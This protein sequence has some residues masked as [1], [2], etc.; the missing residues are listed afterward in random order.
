[1]LSNPA[2]IRA[3][4][5]ELDRV[6]GA[7]RTPTFADEPSLPFIRGMVKETLRLRPINKF[8]NNHYN[9]EDD[10][11]E[12]HFI[13]R[14]SIIMAN[15]WAIHYDASVYPEPEKFLPERWLD[16]RYSAAQAAALADGDLRD[17]LSY[18]GGRRI[19]AGMHLAEKSMFINMAR[20]L[21]GFDLGL[22]TDE[23]G[24][25]IEVDFGTTGLMEGSGSIPKPFSCRMTPRSAGREVILREE[26]RAAQETGID[27]SHVKFST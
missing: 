20:L 12:G 2:A 26:W 1:M 27:F 15:W 7:N 3:A 11:Y 23:M 10:W 24:Q 21:W 19:C 13:P 14:G 8:G 5:A 17:H 9:T 6:V 16:Y 18:G 22:A 25:V 4:Q